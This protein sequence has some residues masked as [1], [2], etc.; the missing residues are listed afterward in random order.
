[1]EIKT[2]SALQ[3]LSQKFISAKL[4][5]CRATGLRPTPVGALSSCLVGYSGVWFPGLINLTSTKGQNLSMTSL[6]EMHFDTLLQ[7]INTSENPRICCSTQIK[8]GKRGFDYKHNLA[9]QHYK[10]L[11][12]Y[13]VSIKM[14]KLFQ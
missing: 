12:L 10:R 2:K 3:A 6:R 9:W 1:M 11:V 7:E 8:L 4:A 5:S 13:A 14:M